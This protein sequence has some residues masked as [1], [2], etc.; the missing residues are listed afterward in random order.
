VA[1][2]FMDFLV[3]L[4]RADRKWRY[5]YTW[6]WI[7]LLSSIPTLDAA[8]WGRAARIT[9]I[10]RVVRAVRA[11]AMISRA[12]LE[13]RSQ[14]AFFAAALLAVVSSSAP[15]SP[16]CTSRRLPTPT[17]SVPKTPRGGR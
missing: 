11:S 15:A 4:W 6:G 9:R 8:R 10:L 3:S 7:D 17:S 14:S 13:H 5:L 12:V 2:F 16:S 1:V